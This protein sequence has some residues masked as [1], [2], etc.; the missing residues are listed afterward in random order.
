MVF[1][2]FVISEYFLAHKWFPS[3][4]VQ[5]KPDGETLI[6]KMLE[7]LIRELKIIHKYSGILFELKK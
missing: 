7:Y 3:L 6:L 1:M 4:L 5:M 2:S